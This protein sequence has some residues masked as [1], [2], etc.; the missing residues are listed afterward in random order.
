MKLTQFLAS[1]TSDPKLQEAFTR[2]PHR[3]M[4][5]RGLSEAECLLFVSNDPHDL[6][7]AI[8]DEVL[9]L[10]KVRSPSPTP[11]PGGGKLRFVSIEPSTGAR[12]ATVLAITTLLVEGTGTLGLSQRSDDAGDEDVVVSLLKNGDTIITGE[13]KGATWPDPQGRSTVTALYSVPADAPTGDY[14]VVTTINLWP[15]SRQVQSPPNAFTVT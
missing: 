12:G 11:W 2:D 9:D 5:E 8:A 10:P 3:T 4:T 1:V 14:S 13:V 15:K 7:Q 6:A